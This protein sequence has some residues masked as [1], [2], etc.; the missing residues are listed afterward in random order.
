MTFSCSLYVISLQVILIAYF[1]SEIRDLV[2]ELKT[3]NSNYFQFLSYFYFLF[4]LFLFWDLGLGNSV[5]SHVTVT[6][7]H[8]MMKN[9]EGLRTNNII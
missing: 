4:L 5:M 2:L 3:E 6:E 8:D 9:K 1:K 7:S